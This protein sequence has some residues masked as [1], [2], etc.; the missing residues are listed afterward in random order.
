M[1]KT[2]SSG[3][4]RPREVLDLERYVPALLVFLANKL[5]SGT[6]AIFRRHFGIGTTE[7]RV[8]AMLAVE[9]WIA[10]GRVCKVIGFDKAAVSRA[11]AVLQDKELIRARSH[12]SDGRSLVYALSDKGWRLHGRILA[13]SLEREQRL[14]GD[15]SAAERESLIDLLNRLL[16]RIPD[17]NAPVD[18]PPGR[19]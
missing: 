9:P 8:M 10:A 6:S 7:W 11:L 19:R 4:G 16:R 14:L 3:R 15:L 12:R 2:K 17:V 13:I 18:V 5:T 1:A